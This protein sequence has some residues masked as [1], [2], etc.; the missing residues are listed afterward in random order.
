MS[1]QIVPGEAV[2]LRLAVKRTES[3]PQ[4]GDHIIGT[5]NSSFWNQA[6]FE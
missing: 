5:M 2:R 1:E 4:V 6:Q 3:P